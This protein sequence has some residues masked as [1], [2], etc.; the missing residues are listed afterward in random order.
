MPLDFDHLLMQVKAMDKCTKRGIDLSD[1]TK[2]IG[3]HCD[4]AEEE[5]KVVGMVKSKQTCSA[6]TACDNNSHLSGLY[7]DPEDND[8]SQLRRTRTNTKLY[9]TTQTCG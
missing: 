7:A 8:I 6:K 5:T 3:E 2:L 9:K 4:E 1:V